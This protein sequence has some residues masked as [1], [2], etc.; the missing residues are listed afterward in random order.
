MM[1]T[2]QACVRMAAAGVLAAGLAAGVAAQAVP[3]ASAA[4]ARELA[5]LMEGK[6]LEAF[7]MRESPISDRFIAVMLVPKVQLLAVSAVY[8]R[9]TD[10]EYRL[11]NKDY[12]TAYRDLAGGSLA[13]E[14]FFVEDVLGDGLVSTP[15]KNAPPDSVT[16]GA[17]RHLLAGPADPKKRNDTRM[18]ADA[19]AKVFADA[20]QQYAKLLDGLIAELKKGG[21]LVPAGLLR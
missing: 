5:S 18:A 9:P 12:V 2:A 1:G 13:K 11:Y 15:A 4:K 8:T 14:R 3:T 7:A 17:T 20:D 19:Y 16:I 21:A 10:I 6:Q